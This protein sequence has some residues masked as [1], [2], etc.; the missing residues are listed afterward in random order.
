MNDIFTGEV[1]LLIFN[2]YSEFI[3]KKKSEIVRI[4]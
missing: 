1:K 3:N 2:Q 4:T